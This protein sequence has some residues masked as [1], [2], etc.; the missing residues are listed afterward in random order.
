[1]PGS[2]PFHNLFWFVDN[3]DRSTTQRKK[4]VGLIYLVA[5]LIFR[6]P[7]I[8]IYLF[9][10]FF[11]F[12]YAETFTIPYYFRI[13]GMNSVFFLTVANAAWLSFLGPFRRVVG[14]YTHPDSKG[15]KNE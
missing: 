6:F 8:P 3:V 5:W 7:G 12:N 15:I 13:F 1:M 9:S 2:T 11:I 4:N 10:K 14:W